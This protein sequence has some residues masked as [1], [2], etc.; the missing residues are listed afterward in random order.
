MKTFIVKYK[1]KSSDKIYKMVIIEYTIGF[2]ICVK[3]KFIYYLK[4]IENNEC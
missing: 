4:F 1:K 3:I 2:E